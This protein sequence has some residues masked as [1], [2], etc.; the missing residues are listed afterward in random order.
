MAASRL[1]ITYW[2]RLEPRPRTAIIEEALAARVRD[3]LWFLTRQWQLGE[4]RGEDAG[5]IAYV[6]VSPQILPID[7]AP[8]EPAALGE[9]HRADLATRAELG[10]AFLD[11]LAASPLAPE[12][13]ASARAFYLGRY[14]LPAEAS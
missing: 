1:S 4:F 10:L 6:S 13:I 8:L 5:S 7:G 9:P 3:P 2:N 14:P 11:L 12:A